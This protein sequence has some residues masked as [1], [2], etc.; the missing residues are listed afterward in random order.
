MIVAQAHSVAVGAALRAVI[1][2]ADEALDV[3]ASEEQVLCVGVNG[4][5]SVLGDRCSIRVTPLTGSE[6][7]ASANS[8]SDAVEADVDEFVSGLTLTGTVLVGTDDPGEE[9]PPARAAAT[10][11]TR[12][13]LRQAI[14]APLLA[15]G[16]A[17]GTLVVTREAD[18]P[19][20]SDDDINFITALADVLGIAVQSARV[21]NDAM[22]TVEDLRQQVQVTDSI[23]DA[24]VACDSAHLI[25]SWNT[26]AEAIY[27]YSRDDA[28]GCHLFT[29]LATEFYNVEGGQMSPEDVFAELAEVGQW[30]GEFRER[31]ADGSPLVVLSS[32]TQIY[33]G[34]RPTGLV[35]VGRDVTAQRREEY[36]A[37]HDALTGLPNRRLL[38]TRLYEALARAV[39]TDQPIA[40]LFIDLD[41]FKPIN[42]TYGHAAGDEVL[43]TTA[44][45]LLSAVRHSDTVGR[46]GGDEF[47]VIL[48]EA[49]GTE[50]I[51]RAAGRI[52]SALSEP[53]EVDG[54]VV[55]VLPS[56]GVCV[57]EHPASDAAP[58][59]RMLDSADRAMYAA[60]REKS[61]IVFV[62]PD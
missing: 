27:G 52:T 15:R 26:G 61:G 62:T 1:A 9:S 44:E 37:M 36:Q 40:V 35:A 45:R 51:T 13:A 58:A 55:T 46:L 16:R 31:K 2:V 20:Y 23:S 29:L 38:N 6:P 17:I 43:T 10:W 48:E 42:D 54:A 49:G 60:K 41:G 19:P 39:R 25:V 33:D 8:H 14:V 57:S 18:R 30:R 47:L 22:V 4:V 24:L 32:L 34:A 21:R 5:G 3:A 7:P 59:E 12:H 50:H 11:L 28:I 56:I 53:I